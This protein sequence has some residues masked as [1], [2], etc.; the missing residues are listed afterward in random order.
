MKTLA[1]LTVLSAACLLSG[2][3][4]SLSPNVEGLSN[5]KNE[6]KTSRRVTINHNDRMLSDDW[7]RVWLTDNPSRLSPFPVTDTSGQPR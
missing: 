1:S 4:Q 3:G 6:A 2:C 5:T 7:R